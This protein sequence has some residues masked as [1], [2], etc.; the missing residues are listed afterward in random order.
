VAISDETTLDPRIRRT[1][2]LL[3]E[4]LVRLLRK[5][6]F[7]AISVQDIAEEATINRAT[8]YAHYPDKYAL[9]ECVTAS[10]FFALLEERGARFDGACSEALKAIV[11]GVCDYLVEMRQVDCE[12]HRQTEPHMES[13]M[14]A[15]I[16]KMLSDGLRQHPPAGD[17]S[18]ELLAAAAS[19]AIFGGAKQWASGSDRVR[20]EQVVGQIVDLV[21]PILFGQPAASAA[22]PTQK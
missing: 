17:R 14:I 20:A 6:G 12:N 21:S 15:V 1:R 22:D 4:A 3:Q 19:W 7:D 5:K 13:A 16:R 18:P 8:F 10:R 2:L 9:L 11:L